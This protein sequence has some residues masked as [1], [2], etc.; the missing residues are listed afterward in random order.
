MFVMN[1]GLN[2]SLR[3]G[4]F[5]KP[6][7]LFFVVGKNKHAI[8]VSFEEEAISDLLSKAKVKLSYPWVM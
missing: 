3:T 6:G 2:S 8:Q 7:V 5:Y 4:L 1:S